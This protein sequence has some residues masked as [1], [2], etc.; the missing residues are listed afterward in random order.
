[1]GLKEKDIDMRKLAICV[2]FVM[3]LLSG[4]SMSIAQDIENNEQIV[5]AGG[6][7][8]QFIDP[9]TQT[10]ISLSDEI[11][12]AV[13]ASPSWSPDRTQ[14]VYEAPVGEIVELHII[15]LATNEVDKLTQENWLRLPRWSPDGEK[16]AY[17]GGGD[18][19]VGIYLINPDGTGKQLLIEAAHLNS[20]S[21]SPDGQSLIYV[22]SDGFDL[23]IATSTE[24]DTV[25]IINLT[26]DIHLCGEG[27][28]NFKSASWSRTT[29]DI[30][31]ILL[32][33]D[34]K[35]YLLDIDDTDGYGIQ[36]A[37][38]LLDTNWQD[39]GTLD[40]GGLDWSSDGT[41]LV[42]LTNFTPNDAHYT[43]VLRFN[44]RHFLETNQRNISIIEI[45]YSEF[46]YVHPAW[47]N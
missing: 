17:I 9:A 43:L 22:D 1:M 26:E 13:W 16:I 27:L 44:V 2:M 35:L 32:C 34:P 31:T 11:Q 37:T 8:F 25:D 40:W 42:L 33:S 30:A 23:Y 24:S 18:E 10:E 38:L 12:V 20:L 45:S 29:G 46:G 39:F 19:G 5:V 41:E 47:Q 6:L 36:E 4:Q 28:M 21:W 7:S 3:L 15:N 14:V